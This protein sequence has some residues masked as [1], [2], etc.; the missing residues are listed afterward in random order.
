MKVLH[1]ERLGSQYIL[2]LVANS[3]RKSAFEAVMTLTTDTVIKRNPEIVHADMDDEIVMMSIEKGEYFGIDAIGSRIWEMLEGEKSIGEICAG[4]CASY[5][6]DE[7][8]CRQDVIRFLE[9]MHERNIIET[10]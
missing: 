4:L 5:D 10:V 1:L 9:N 2:Y 6:V 7:S 8:V 3:G